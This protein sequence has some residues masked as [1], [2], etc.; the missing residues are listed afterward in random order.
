[1]LF[2]VEFFI[3]V[4]VMKKYFTNFSAFLMLSSLLVLSACNSSKVDE[5]SLDLPT[6]LTYTP[7]S[8]TA[9][10]GTA[11]SSSKP[12]VSGTTPVTFTL[13]TSPNAGTAL[14]IDPNTGI[15]TSTAATAE[16]TYTIS[17]SA[18]N[19]AGNVNFSNALTVIITSSGGNKIT[20][21]TDIKPIINNNCMPCHVNGGGNTNYT[22]Y[23][24]AKNNI[25]AIIDRVNRTQGSGGFMPKVGSKLSSVELSALAQWKT[26]GLLEN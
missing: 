26:D 24:A 21:D 20:Y 19:I 22:V 15:V 12:M 6:N 9:V 10:A 4:L 18:N 14:V 17:V 3:F 2:L 11:V 8:I 23:T 7:N 5:P 25:N 13:S 1:M 16:G